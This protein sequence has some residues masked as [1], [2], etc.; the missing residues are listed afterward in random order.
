M[1]NPLISKLNHKLTKIKQEVSLKIIERIYWYLTLLHSNLLKY[2]SN[3]I[4][5]ETDL[6]NYTVKHNFSPDTSW[7]GSWYLKKRTYCD[8]LFANLQGGNHLRNI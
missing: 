6:K 8:Q 3:S 1:G 2:D 5:Y 4:N 7:G